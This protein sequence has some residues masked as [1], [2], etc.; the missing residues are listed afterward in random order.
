MGYLL[1]LFYKCSCVSIFKTKINKINDLKG[2]FQNIFKNVGILI[3]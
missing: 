3:S 1:V 2:E